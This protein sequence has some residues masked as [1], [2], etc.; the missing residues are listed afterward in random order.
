MHQEA[1]HHSTMIELNFSIHYYLQLTFTYFLK[2]L[3]FVKTLLKK[4]KI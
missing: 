3:V 1:K 4:K 2:Y